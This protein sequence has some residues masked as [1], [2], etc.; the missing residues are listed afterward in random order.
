MTKKLSIP[1]ASIEWIVARMHVS[2][3]DEYVKTDIRHRCTTNG[4][5][6]KSIVQAEV[7]AVKCHRKNQELY[8]A[9]MSGKL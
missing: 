3:S 7:Y 6:E 1:K 2:E 9:V 4:W 8:R 5:T